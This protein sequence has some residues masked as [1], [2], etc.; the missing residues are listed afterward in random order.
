VVWLVTKPEE[1]DLVSSQPREVITFSR[2]L[3]RAARQAGVP[4][5]HI[6]F[7]LHRGLLAETPPRDRP[8][9][10]SALALTGEG[11]GVAELE[12]ALVTVRTAHPDVEVMAIG[13]VPVDGA[14]LFRYHP[15]L[16]SLIGPLLASAIHLVAAHTGGA[17]IASLA[18]AAGCAVVTTATPDVTE[19][20]LPGSTALVA[21]VGDADGLA[22]AVI[23]LLDDPAR[24]ERI[25]TE[26]S[27]DARRLLAS[28]PEA[29]RRLVLALNGPR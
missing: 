14:T 22:S 18:Q 8:L 13:G 15:S 26:G 12:A 24:R 11:N 3:A 25:A 2:W 16:F 29:A 23:S 21:P 20:V 27:C 4:A 17:E 1:L 6:P 5:V 10:V 9:A 7:G 28:W 19:V